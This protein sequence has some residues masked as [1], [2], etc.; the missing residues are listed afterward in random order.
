MIFALFGLEN[1]A[2]TASKHCPSAVFRKAL[3]IQTSGILD[4][5]GKKT[6]LHRIYKV[7]P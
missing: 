7:S 5:S 4:R 2:E 1:V 6:Y 3:R